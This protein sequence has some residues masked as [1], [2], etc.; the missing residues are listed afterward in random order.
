MFRMISRLSACV[1]VPLTVVAA[2]AGGSTALAQSAPTIALVPANNPPPVPSGMKVT[3][4]TGPDSLQSSPTCPVI[5]Y[6]GNTT[7]AFSFIDNRVSYGIVTYDAA[8]NVVKN[9]TRDGARYVYKMTVDPNAKTV[10]VWGQANAKVDVAWSD[11]PT[12]APEIVQVP[13]NAP[14]PVPGGLKVTCLKGPN[15]LESSPT[16][17]VIKYKGHTTWAFSFIDNRVAYGVV[18]YDASNNVLANNTQNG[19][20]YVYKITV[21]PNAQ[22]VTIW[23]QADA[24]VTVPWSA[25]P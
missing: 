25:L 9:V 11:L 8:N 24:K 16:C 15:T 10:G 4:L 21:D 12:A 6:G 23:G 17:P 3:C 19:A 18:T 14:P 20:R 7:W 2:L 13:A 1:L 22:T 5:Q